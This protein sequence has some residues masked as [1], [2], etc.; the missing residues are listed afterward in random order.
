ML[1]PGAPSYNIKVYFLN[2]AQLVKGNDVQD[3]AITPNGQAEV[4]IQID[5]S[6]YTP[7]REGTGSVTPEASTTRRARG[8][9]TRSTRGS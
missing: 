1:G 4:T 6:D 7:L 5:S 2:A 9:R 3:L 8:R